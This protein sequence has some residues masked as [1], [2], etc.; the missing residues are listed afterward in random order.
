MY[1]ARQ[2]IS[3][4]IVALAK[5]LGLQSLVWKL[6]LGGEVRFWNRY[7]STGGLQWKEEFHRRLDPQLPLDGR[8]V[9]LLERVSASAEEYDVLDVGSGPLTSLGKTIPGKTVRLRA[10]DPL[11]PEYDKMLAEQNLTPPV[12]TE[13]CKGEELSGK[14]DKSTFDLVYAR[15][16]MDHSIDPVLA[17]REMLAVTKPG[18][19]VYLEHWPNE[20]ETEEYRGL[21][22]WNF[23]CQDGEFVVWNPKRRQVVS[24]ELG[25]GCR[26]E[27]VIET[28]EEEREMIVVH[29]WKAA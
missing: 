7:F 22:Q 26:I 14:F 28:V 9:A 12:R 6:G 27:C 19:L 23:D 20:G 13:E 29:M 25:D 8:I 4:A 1:R 18:G 3:K 21:H 24:E 10:V 11:A 16:C 5:A 15:N 2:F 17:F